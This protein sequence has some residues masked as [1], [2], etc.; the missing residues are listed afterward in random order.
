V[1]NKLPCPH[2]YAHG[3]GKFGNYLTPIYSM[4]LFIKVVIDLKFR[5]LN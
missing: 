1:S 4:P 5:G 3:Y 2:V